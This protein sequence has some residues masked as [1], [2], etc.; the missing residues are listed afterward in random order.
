L[1]LSGSVQFR[2]ATGLGDG[3]R[4]RHFAARAVRRGFGSPKNRFK[5]GAADGCWAALWAEAFSGAPGPLAGPM[6]RRGLFCRR[7][8]PHVQ[9]TMWIM[10]AVEGPWREG[11]RGSFQTFIAG[12][13]NNGPAQS[14]ISSGV[15]ALPW[16]TIPLQR[17]AWRVRARRHANN[18]LEGPKTRIPAWASRGLS[19]RSLAMERA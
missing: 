8:H 5:A 7:K 15:S 16:K 10:W 3:L 1:R 18:S 9:E 11:G 4:A 12:R 19:G 17:K 13:A 6:G 14:R 2:G